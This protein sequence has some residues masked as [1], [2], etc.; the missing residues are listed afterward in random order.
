M[1]KQAIPIIANKFSVRDK[2]ELSDFKIIGINSKGNSFTYY[3]YN[4][5]FIVDGEPNY[6][7]FISYKYLLIIFLLLI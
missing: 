5:N 1:I 6:S 2:K 4:D 7:K 3:F